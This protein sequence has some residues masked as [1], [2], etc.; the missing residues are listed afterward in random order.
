MIHNE[1]SI[2]NDEK[3]RESQYRINNVL[4]GW[5]ENNRNRSGRN[6]KHNSQLRYRY[7]F[8]SETGGSETFVQLPRPKPIVNFPDESTSSDSYKSDITMWESYSSPYT[9]SYSD[10]YTSSYTSSY[11][12]SYTSSYTSSYSDSY[13]DS[14]RT[15]ESS[16]PDSMFIESEASLSH[17]CIYRKERSNTEL[18]TTDSD[19]ST[20]DQYS[21]SYSPFSLQTTHA[22]CNNTKMNCY[23]DELL[24]R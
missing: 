5:L 8:E 18:S 14:Y 10:S 17:K 15:T 23:T 16:A 1:N 7:G 12:D 24:H 13:S 3:I 21:S 22:V 4:F 11:S 20:I 19:I 2:E 6:I 9:S